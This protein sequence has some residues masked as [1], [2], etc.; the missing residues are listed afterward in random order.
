MEK[1]ILI[2]AGEPSGDLHGAN[3]VR[4][5]KEIEPDIKISGVGGQFMRRQGVEIYQDISDL[6]TFGFFDA[7]KKINRFLKL[8]ALLLEKIKEARPQA[9]ILIDFSGFNLRFAKEINHALFASEASLQGRKAGVN[10][11]IPLFYYI[12]PQVWISRRGRI[13][14]I[15]R[16][17]DKM[18]VIFKFEKEFYRRYG[19]DAEF[20]GH[21]LLDIVRPQ[22]TKEEIR[23]EFELSNNLIVSLFPG[24]R[25]TEVKMILPIMLKTASLILK[26]LSCQFIIA[27]AKELDIN[28]YE[29]I[30]KDFDLEIKVIDNRVYD[31]LE[32]SDFCL[33]CSGTATIEAA[34]MNRP[35]VII[36]KT[37]LPNYFFYRPQVKA[38]YIG[39][40]NIIAGKRIIDEFVQFGAKP[41]IIS[42]KVLEI[43]KDPV[44]ISQIKKDLAKVKENLGSPGASKR[45]AEIILETLNS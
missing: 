25:K 13:K 19:I 1:K 21:P 43:L 39:M 7:I 24:S 40:V 31:C 9:I 17:I 42:K 36:Y 37:S 41:E 20:V 28:L 5:L 14:T 8:R 32:V 29:E 33:I 10:K 26:E 22:K 11:R 4:A 16:Y 23:K 38:P 18:I 27:K 35:F 15:R 6:T 44:K 30:L 45:T 34:I 2:I 3:L 12:S